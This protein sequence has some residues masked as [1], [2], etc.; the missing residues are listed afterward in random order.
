[1]EQSFEWDP[2]TVAAASHSG[3][4]RSARA[5]SFLTGIEAGRTWLGCLGLVVATVLVGF[6]WSG[7]SGAERRCGWLSNPTPAN[8]WL[9]DRDGTW[10]LGQQGG[11]QAPGLDDMGDL[12]RRGW[13][14][15]NGSSYGYGCVCMEVETERARMR[16][17]RVV[18]ATPIPVARC[19]ADRS[20]PGAPE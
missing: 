10:T 3:R 6:A 9:Q 14:V 11:Y 8:W 16:V 4:E 13:V 1:M 19:R 20:L 18:S 12:A 7:A 5:R 2:S 15:T 17:R